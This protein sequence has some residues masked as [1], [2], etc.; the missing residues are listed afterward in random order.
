MK[1]RKL[2]R[3][4]P[5]KVIR[6]VQR[7]RNRRSD[8]ELRQIALD[9]H[10]QRIFC[11]R[12]C[13]SQAEVR[14]AFPI[15]MLASERQRKNIAEAIG[16]RK[17]RNGRHRAPGMLFEYYD[18]AAPLAA[19]GLPMFFSVR[20]LDGVEHHKVAVMISKLAKAEREA[21]A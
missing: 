20:V 14:S 6:R 11:D 2:H 15:L 10:R 3:P 19:N 18:K 21:L 13:Y 5:A 9:I 12:M 4:D 8:D 16:A 7:A 17:G 1:R